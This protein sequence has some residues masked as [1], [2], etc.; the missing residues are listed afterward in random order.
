MNAINNLSKSEYQQVA[1]YIHG[2]REE[3]QD[4]IELFPLEGIWEAVAM[5][6]KVEKKVKKERNGCHG[7][8]S[9]NDNPRTSGWKEEEEHHLAAQHLIQE[10]ATKEK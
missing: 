8:S 3:I 2:L 7:Q 10:E 9:W 4:R 1:R 6:L 5:A